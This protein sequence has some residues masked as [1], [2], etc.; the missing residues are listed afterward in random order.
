M[1]SRE[2]V[3]RPLIARPLVVRMGALGDMVML[4]PLLKALY[5]R[6]GL[7]ADLVACGEWN[8]TLFAQSPWVNQIYTVQSRNT[9]FWF[10]PSKQAMVR[11]LK[12]YAANR[13]WFLFEHLP[14]LHRLMYRAHCDKALATLATT[15][16]RQ[17]GEHT[18]EHF[19]RMADVTY[20][21]SAAQLH[22]SAADIDECKAWLSETKKN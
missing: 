10:S 2:E 1:N 16:P 7:A 5:E 6:T 17:L 8:R 11:Q 3:A 21:P 14:D 12:P 13:P 15:H 19:L 20:P 22:C 9:P 4:T 18:C